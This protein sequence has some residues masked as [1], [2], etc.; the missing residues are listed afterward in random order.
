MFTPQH[1]LSVIYTDFEKAFNKVLHNRLVSK[2]GSYAID[3]ALVNGL[4]HFYCIGYIR[5]TVRVSSQYLDFMPVIS[6][7]P[8]LAAYFIPAASIPAQDCFT[9]AYKLQQ[10]VYRE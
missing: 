8:Q 1:E 6:S 10:V 4:E 3:E 7:I 9:K 5:Y 2:L